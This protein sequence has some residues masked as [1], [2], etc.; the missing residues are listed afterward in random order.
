MVEPDASLGKDTDLDD[1]WELFLDSTDL[2]ETLDY[3]VGCGDCQL[4][5]DFKRLISTFYCPGFYC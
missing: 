4:I 5:K 2:F 3:A 1:L